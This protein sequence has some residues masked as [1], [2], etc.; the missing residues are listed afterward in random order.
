MKISRKIFAVLLAVVLAFSVFAVCASAEG[1]EDNFMTVTVITDKG[2]E[3]YQTGEDVKVSV[4]IACNY[5]ATCFR[6]P[7]MYDTSVLKA[8]TILSVTAKGSCASNGTLSYNKSTDGSF[9][10]ENYDGSEWGC[11]LVQWLGTVQNGTVGC[12]NN[13]DGEITFE[14]TLKVLDEAAGTGTIFI[15]EESDLFYNQAIADPTDATTFYTVPNMESVLTLHQANVTVAGGD[16]TLVPNAAYDSQAIVDETNLYVYGLQEGLMSASGFTPF[17]K[18]SN[19][20]AILSITPGDDGY[21]TG[22]KINIVL[23]NTVLRTYTVIIFGDVTGDCVCDANDLTPVMLVSSNINSFDDRPEIIFAGD[24]N[25]DKKVD[26]ND[27]SKYLLV[28]NMKTSIDQV[29]PY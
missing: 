23:G 24:L 4:S 13:P 12:F 9:I 14:F 1:E 15:P 3:S 29:N 25:G 7:I 22:A 11:V 2:A 26:A 20:N 8:P 16:E 18:P 5:N 17:V 28:S 6:F 19:P 21:G 27:L 10:P